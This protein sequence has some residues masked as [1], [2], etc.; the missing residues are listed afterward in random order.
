MSTKSHKKG[1]KTSRA[2]MDESSVSNS[3]LYTT[4][5][6]KKDEIYADLGTKSK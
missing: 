2:L 1:G 5:E 6:L 3:G 4:F